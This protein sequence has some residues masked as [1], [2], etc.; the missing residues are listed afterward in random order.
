MAGSNNFRN[1]F[2]DITF[3]KSLFVLSKICFFPLNSSFEALKFQMLRSNLC[4]ITTLLLGVFLT[5]ILHSAF[6]RELPFKY[7]DRVLVYHLAMKFIL[8]PTIHIKNCLSIKGITNIIQKLFSAHKYLNVT[9]LKN[10]IEIKYQN[11]RFILFICFNIFSGYHSFYY[12]I[13]HFCPISNSYIKALLIIL[14]ILLNFYINIFVYFNTEIYL[15]IIH[16]YELFIKISTERLNKIKVPFDS[17]NVGCILMYLYEI[18]YELN[19]NFGLQLICMCSHLLI[20]L[21][22]KVFFI[23]TLVKACF[24]HYN[25]LNVFVINFIFYVYCLLSIIIHS[26]DVHFKVRILYI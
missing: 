10:S 5:N 4:L 2:K 7:D 20:Y 3:F 23:Y 1:D 19:T 21:W 16:L 26:E 9:N 6:K 17:I 8:I 18:G 24:R 11:L 14:I 25:R 12:H 15:T 22:M 13:S